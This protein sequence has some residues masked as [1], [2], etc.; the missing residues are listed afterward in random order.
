MI[1]KAGVP[2]TKVIVGVTSYG[3]SFKMAK[4]GCVDPM[5]TFLGS[6]TESLVRK[7]VCT[8]ESGYISNAEIEN[9]A[10]KQATW[11]IDES[12]SDILVYNDTK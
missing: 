11:W 4:K 10:N 2:S 5:C 6:S 8:G 12:D 7:G 9:I 3:R 1:T